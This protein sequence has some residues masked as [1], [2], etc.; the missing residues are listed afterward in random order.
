VILKL[1]GRRLILPWNTRREIASGISDSLHMFEM[2]WIS[3][4]I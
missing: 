4:L 3:R 2:P 1:R